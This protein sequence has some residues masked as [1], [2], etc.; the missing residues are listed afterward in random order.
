M[1]NLIRNE[2]YKVFHKKSIIVF[3]I[4]IL[5]MTILN[6]WLY[7]TNYDNDGNFIQNNNTTSSDMLDTY[8]NELKKYDY[9]KED[10]VLEYISNKTNYDREKIIS[11]NKYT[12][13]NWQYEYLYNDEIYNAI[14]YINY[15]TYV[16]KDTD[17]LSSY[18]KM[19]DSYLDKLKN[20]DWKYFVNLELDKVN[21]E[22]QKYN[23]SELKVKKEVLEYRLNKNISLD[24]SYMNNALNGYESITNTLN[25]Y[26]EYDKLNY[27]DKLAYQRALKEQKINKYI[28]DTG[29]N[30]LKQNDLRSGI[31]DVVNDYEI[32]TI[33]FVIIIASGIVSSEFK[34]GTIKQ[35]LV[36]P[37]KRTT[38]LLAKYLTC[39]ICLF[40]VVSYTTI[41]EF[42][43]RSLFFSFDGI[44]VPMLIYNYNTNKL[45]EFNPLVY[46]LI[47]FIHRLPQFILL[48]TLA[49]S[50]STIFTSTS[51]A[52]TFTILGYMTA[53]ILNTLSRAFNLK[54]MN[55]F[56]T[57]NWDFRNYLFGALPNYEGFN[58]K[59][60]SIICLIYLV[61]MLV[62]SFTIFKKKNIK[63]I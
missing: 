6:S 1:I 42:I 38:I 40:L 43:V 31:A 30:V 63:N 4:L 36:K 57:L 54:F 34:D 52:N 8:L 27:E 48:L 5:G 55:Y 44:D 18:Q 45:L 16:E 37:Y 26:G 62:V 10:E 20:N 39:I 51:L 7:K 21:N 23:T 15:Y 29:K 60:S 59:F 12:S 11:D 41:C 58:I 25:S 50:L 28:I 22:L 17:K 24:N 53:D 9:N 56:V 33:L 46:M 2:L 32:F 61:I 14:Y 3:A 19:L 47:I 13:D 35:L 49:F